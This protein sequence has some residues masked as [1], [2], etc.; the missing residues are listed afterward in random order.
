MPEGRVRTVPT[1]RRSRSALRR[2]DILAGLKHRGWCSLAA[3]LVAC[4]THAPA[5]PPESAP[6][7]L[8]SAPLPEFRRPT[9]RGATFDTAAAGDRVIVVKF[10]AKHCV[11]CRRSLPAAEALHRDFPDVTV[12]GISE[13]PDLAA[14]EEQVRLH[15]LTF[16]VVLDRDNVLAG[17]FRVSELP[18]AFVTDRQRRIAWVM[19][20]DHADEDLRRTVEWLRR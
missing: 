20:P 8:A 19:G 12:V 13:D 3:V 4:T 7:A 2:S 10:F 18:M 9:L 5:E 14:A 17:R 6:S 16:P 15:R 1:I 11:P